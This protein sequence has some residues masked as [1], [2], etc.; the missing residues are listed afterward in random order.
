M[1]VNLTQVP[2]KFQS[3]GT[4]RPDCREKLVKRREKIVKKIDIW[5]RALKINRLPSATDYYS[6]VDELLQIDE[7]IETGSTSEGQASV[8]EVDAKLELIQKAAKFSETVPIGGASMVGTTEYKVET[9]DTSKGVKRR[10]TGTPLICL[11]A[12]APTQ[13]QINTDDSDSD[14]PP[15]N[16]KLDLRGVKIPTF[17]NTASK[18]ATWWPRFEGLIHRN[19]ELPYIL[20][21]VKLEECLVGDA[22][23]W[24]ENLKPTKESYKEFVQCAN[25]LKTSTFRRQRS[26]KSLMRSRKSMTSTT[27]HRFESY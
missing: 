20:K 12:S 18:W 13:L 2:L 22:Q 8:E 10:R 17:D 27:S 9:P 11:H 16:A 14:E 4:L 3:D 15:D 7:L 19:K 26:T 24:I 1:E 5:A 23:R 25:I 6:I 21:V